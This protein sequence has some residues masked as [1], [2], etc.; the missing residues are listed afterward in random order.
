MTGA[1]DAGRAHPAR[2]SRP[3]KQLRLHAINRTDAEVVP[4]R[5][6]VSRHLKLDEQV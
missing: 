3:S 4:V 1:S 6:G 2:R 5:M